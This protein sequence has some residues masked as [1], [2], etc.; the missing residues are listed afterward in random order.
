[1]NHKI[2]YILRWYNHIIIGSLSQ[3][4]LEI[5]RPGSYITSRIQVFY[6]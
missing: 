3:I 5:K 6:W 4:P 2:I 1:M